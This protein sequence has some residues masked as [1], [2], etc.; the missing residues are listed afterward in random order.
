MVG[1]SSSETRTFRSRPLGP[2]APCWLGRSLG[3]LRC[4]HLG[5]VLPRPVQLPGHGPGGE[6]MTG[7]WS[8]PTRTA[9]PR[10]PSSA[11]PSART[12]PATVARFPDHEA[13]VVPFQDVRLTYA[14]LDAAVDDL[15]R[16]APRGRHREGRPRRDLEPQLR[17]VGARPVRH[18]PH[19]RHP[20]QPQPGLP[21][22]RGGLRA[23]AVR[24]PAAGRR[25]VVQDQRLRGDGDRGA[26]D[27]SPRSSAWSSSAPRSGTSSS[28]RAPPSTEAVLASAVG[29]A[30]VR[31]PD[32]HPV[33]ERH[34]GLPQGRHAR[35]TTTS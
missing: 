30:A 23:A 26:P 27:G 17:R 29:R 32:Q 28:P 15:A 31:R 24:L 14:Q 25:A 20:R 18:R 8:S 3:S 33:H 22:P 1:R 34:D 2:S 12:S 19:R 4:G 35:P 10:C 5:T 6:T 9:R 21:H 7:R 16:G 13:L 11:R